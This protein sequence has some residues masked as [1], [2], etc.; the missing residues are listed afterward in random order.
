[1]KLI[2]FLP[3][4]WVSL[5]TLRSVSLRE[6]I[7]PVAALA[8]MIL[9]LF[10]WYWG[11][12][13]NAERFVTL[14]RQNLS[15]K[16]AFQPYHFSTYLYLGYFLVLVLVASI[17]MVNRFQV[18][19]TAAQLIYQVL[20]YMFVAAILFFILITRYEPT[21]LIYIGF[22]IAFI[23]SN[24]FHRRTN[25]WVHELMLWIG[26]GLLVYAQVMAR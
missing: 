14:M 24:F 25:T 22:P 10:T 21:S 8:L 26:L 19:K 23:L 20:F 2:W 13:D 18:R 11:I 17:Y 15:F 7:Y 1:M 9:M 12:M 16:S 4:I 3:L 5:S 6:L